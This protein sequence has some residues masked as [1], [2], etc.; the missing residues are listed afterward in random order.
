[1]CTDQK[2]SWFSMSTVNDFGVVHIVFADNESHARRVFGSLAK[3]G[4]IS[5]LT[6]QLFSDLVGC[7]IPS[8]AEPD[9]FTNN[10]LAF[11]IRGKPVIVWPAVDC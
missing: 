8:W 11:S 1:M 2:G 6:W 5:R 4:N 3:A 10:D 7:V 9:D